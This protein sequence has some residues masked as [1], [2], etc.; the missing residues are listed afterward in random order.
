[1]Q[2]SG[3]PPLIKLPFVLKEPTPLSTV[4]KKQKP[5]DQTGGTEYNNLFF[6]EVPKGK[7]NYSS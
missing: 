3:V 2:R 6:K 7:S 5:P 1:M 4:N